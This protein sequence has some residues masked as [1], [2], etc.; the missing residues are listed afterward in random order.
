L[1]RL[2]AFTALLLGVALATENRYAR[3]QSARSM[4]EPSMT[5]AQIEPHLNDIW[6]FGEEKSL[7]SPVRLRRMRLP[8]YGQYFYKNK[9]SGRITVDF[10]ITKTGYVSDLKIH[11]RPN[12]ALA[13]I[14]T[15]AISKWVFEPPMRSKQAVDLKARKHFYFENSETQDGNPAPLVGLSNRDIEF[16]DWRSIE[17]L[18]TKDLEEYCYLDQGVE[19][20]V[21]DPQPLKYPRSALGQEV[22]GE[23]KMRYKINNDGLTSDLAIVGP[24]VPA[25][26]PT[27]VLH[28]LRLRFEPPRYLGR[29]TTCVVKQTF[30]FNL[31]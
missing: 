19:L 10:K 25:L 16:T 27:I 4:P 30:T 31:E 1:N 3:S 28:I 18:P 22:R 6:F 5:Q 15:E 12:E 14:V 13:I 23:L 29:P 9:I 20:T 2:F 26:A 21:I 24:I 7:D 11:G 8:D 17:R